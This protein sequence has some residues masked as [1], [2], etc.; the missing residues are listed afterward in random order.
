MLGCVLR[1]LTARSFRNSSPF[2]VPCEGREARL[3]H[4]VPIGNRTPLH[5]RCATHLPL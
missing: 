5:Y 3:I 2:T 4:T 1:P